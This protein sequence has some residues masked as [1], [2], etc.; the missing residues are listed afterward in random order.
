MGL[1]HE[2][3]VLLITAIAQLAAIAFASSISSLF[4]Q[5]AFEPVSG[6]GSY[7]VNALIFVLL[8]ALGTLIYLR[9]RKH[10]TAKAVYAAAEAFLIF[11]LTSLILGIQNIPFYLSLVASSAVAIL[12][13]VV[14][15]RGN[16]ISKTALAVLVSSESGAF[17]GIV[18]TPPTLYLILLF[19]AIYDVIAVFKG[20]LKR[21][22]DEPGF[23]MLSMDIGKITMGL[24]DQ[25]FYSMVPAAAFLMKGLLFALV[26]MVVVDSGVMLTMLLLK[27]RKVLP[28]LTIPL[29]LSLL[30]FL[31]PS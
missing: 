26:S 9:L 18:F 24:G 12:A 25:I 20:P 27:K 5:V 22:I 30:L 17:L 16:T 10:R 14:I 6:K 7:V 4:G 28:G 8:P 11:I 15:F 3:F 13:Y 31:L 1:R 19:F 2:G 29:L 21:A 23:G